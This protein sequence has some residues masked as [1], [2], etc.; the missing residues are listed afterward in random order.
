MALARYQQPHKEEDR[1]TFITDAFIKET[2]KE[3]RER[4]KKV[5][6]SYKCITLLNITVRL[7]QKNFFMI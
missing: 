3:K 1:T 4:E 7:L 5:Q 2:E 6:T